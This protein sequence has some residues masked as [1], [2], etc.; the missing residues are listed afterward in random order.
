MIER[1][2]PAR[3]ISLER[4]PPQNIEAEMATLGSMLIEEEAIAVAID[5]LRAPYFYKDT[6]ARIFSAVLDL[7]QNN[8]PVDLITLTE[9]LKNRDE[10]EVVGGSGYLTSLTNI[11]PTAANIEYYAKI[12]K[13]KHLLRS[14]INVATSIITESYE[15]KEEADF[16]LDNAEKMVT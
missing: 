2:K 12:V 15:S 14:L 13:E 11:V 4:V 5:I 9:L 1:A 3:D 6:H 7:Y 16:L 8:K 10:L